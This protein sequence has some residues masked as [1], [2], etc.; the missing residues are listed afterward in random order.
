MS[1]YINAD[2][3]AVDYG[4]KQIYAN[5]GDFEATTGQ[6]RNFQKGQLPGSWDGRAA[7]AQQG[8]F[9]GW[10]GAVSYTHLRAHET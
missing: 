10:D 9:D 3:V 8:S 4:S 7:V 2:P 1:R 5:H 6:L